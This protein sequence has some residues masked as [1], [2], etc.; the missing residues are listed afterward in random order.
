MPAATPATTVSCERSCSRSRPRLTA[1]RNLSR[2]TSRVERIE[3]AQS[4][5]SSRVSRAWRRASST[6]SPAWR[7]ASLTISVCDASRTACSRASP[8]IRSHSR[9]ASRSEE[10][11]SELQSH[12]DLVCRLLLEKKKKKISNQLNIQTII[13]RELVHDLCSP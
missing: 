7:S 13:Y 1:L 5:I 3:S 10:H 9:F 4:S 8:R 6:I 11:T 2:L 12:H